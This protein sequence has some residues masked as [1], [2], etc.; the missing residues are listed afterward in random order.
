MV[1]IFVLY[2]YTKS[3]QTKRLSGNKRKTFTAFGR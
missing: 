2:T 1:G 3:Q